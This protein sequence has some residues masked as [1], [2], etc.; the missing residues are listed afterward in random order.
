[1]TISRDDIEHIAYLAR[2]ELEEDEVEHMREHFVQILE[3]VSQLDELPDKE[4]ASE[5]IRKDFEM[6][7][8]IVD[9]CLT[10]DE[11]LMN[12]S[13]VEDDLIVVPEVISDEGGK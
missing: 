8:D 6:R 1:M 11:A 7:E 13:E 12:S 9:E 3:Y 4:K 2:L 5:G 10:R